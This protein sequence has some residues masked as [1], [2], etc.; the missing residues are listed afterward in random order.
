[1]IR[2]RSVLEILHVAHRT[3]RICRGE[4]VV[5]VHM[6]G[7]AGHAYM[8]SS[9]GK[10]GRAVVKVCLQPGIHSVTGLAICGKAG[11]QVIRH[12]RILKIPHV[13]RIAVRR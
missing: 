8:R 10:A 7:R 2:I 11:C 9:E 6:A 12:C 3:G 5:V 4:I 1:M 13:T